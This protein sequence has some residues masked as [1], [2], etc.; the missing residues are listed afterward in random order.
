MFD[1]LFT[2]PATER[3]HIKMSYAIMT[4]IFDTTPEIELM[5]EFDT[6]T[7]GRLLE[8]KP[9][10][11]DGSR[12]LRPQWTEALTSFMNVIVDPLILHLE[13]ALGTRSSMLALL[14]HYKSKVELFNRDDITV[15]MAQNKKN[16]ERAAKLHLFEYLH[17]NRLVFFVEPTIGEDEP[18]LIALQGTDDPLIVEGK[19]FQEDKRA[20]TSGFHQV[21]RYTQKYHAPIGYLIVYNTKERPIEIHGDGVE[22]NIQYVR[23][24]SG[25]MIFFII[26]ET[27]PN[28]KSASKRPRHNPIVVERNEITTAINTKPIQR[29]A[30]EKLKG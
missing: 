28:P 8:R 25:V 22:A 1:G 13:S 27:M 21:Y 3:D 11:E 12:A 19:I 29:K 26:I 7:I 14:K 15:R 16:A 4:R 10:A 20:I 2:M 23:L 24:P 5:E 6:L 18:D 30:A 17:D 9:I